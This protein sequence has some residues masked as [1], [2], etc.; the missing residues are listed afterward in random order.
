[1]WVGALLLV[2]IPPALVGLI[3]AVSAFGDPR[4]AVDP[5]AIILAT[6]GVLVFA[7]WGLSTFVNWLLGLA[8]SV[9]AATLIARER[10]TRAWPLLRL[11]PLT[12][13]EILGGKFAALLY[14]LAGPLHLVVVLRLVALG[15]GLLTLLL[16]LLAAQ[17]TWAALRET[18]ASQFPFTPFEWQSLA[19]F[20]GLTAVVGTL[21]W[22]IEPY[23][24]ALYNGAVGLAVSTLARTQGAAVVLVFATHFGLGLA[25]YAPAQQM[26]SLLLVVLVRDPTDVGALPALWLTLPFALNALLSGGVF[27]ACLLLAY[28]R[29]DRLGD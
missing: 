17:T 26:L 25:L 12:T 15:G 10:E 19:V 21:G 1:M 27:L 7:A 20:G 9:F 4:R 24:T 23:L 2:L 8:A 22:L 16:V 5:V 28:Y 18:V 11:T 14:R 3:A 29:L 13:M 6:G